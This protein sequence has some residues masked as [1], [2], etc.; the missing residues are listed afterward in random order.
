MKGGVGKTTVAVNLACALATGEN[1]GDNVVAL[2]D[3]D[4]H[5]TATE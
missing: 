4:V 1:L 3:A 5:A 2:A